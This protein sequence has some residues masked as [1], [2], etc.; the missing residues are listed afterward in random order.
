MLVCLINVVIQTLYVEAYTRNLIAREES[1]GVPTPRPQL[2][3]TLEPNVAVIV[4]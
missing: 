1:V 3:P 4:K 2:P